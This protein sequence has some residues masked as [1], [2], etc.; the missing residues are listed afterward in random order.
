MT[1]PN[2]FTLYRGPSLLDGALIIALATGFRIAS[3]NAKTGGAM[4]QTWILRDD[5]DPI[6]AVQTGADFS[7]CG[8]CVHRGETVNGGNVA[9]SCYVNYAFGVR[10][11][12]LAA[13]RGSYPPV[14]LAGVPSLF[15][16]RKV[17][18]GAYG[19][20]AAVP[21][22]IWEAVTARAAGWTGYTHQWAAFPELA[23]WCMASVDDLGER[24]RA[25]LL[26]FRTF[27]VSTSR[28]AGR[29]DRA[30]VACAASEEAGK[31][32]S[33]VACMACGGAGS[34]AR[35]DIV[36]AAHG[37]VGKRALAQARGGAA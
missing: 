24:A 1:R 25:G 19:D 12:W 15:T 31:L 16:G 30:E 32:T 35:C 26:G 5:I 37:D 2:G 17:R 9:R 13:Q 10:N 7:I 20:P 28:D 22:R 29:A 23:R 14:A 8:D 4:L 6:A 34:R 21:I 11:T 33:C 3:A 36:I 18:L 27:R